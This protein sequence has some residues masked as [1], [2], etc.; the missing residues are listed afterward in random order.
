MCEGRSG[1]PGFEDEFKFLKKAQ[2]MKR[3]RRLTNIFRDSEKAGYVL[4]T[5]HVDGKYHGCKICP[6]GRNHGGN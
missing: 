2:F 6:N 3:D 4:P 5:K 1:D